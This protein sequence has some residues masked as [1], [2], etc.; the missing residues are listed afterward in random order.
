MADELIGKVLSVKKFVDGS[1]TVVF[2]HGTRHTKFQYVEGSKEKIDFP[3]ELFRT[4]A[5]SRDDNMITSFNDDHFPTGV[6]VKFREH[7]S[8]QKHDD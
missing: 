7:P 2:L 1:I 8:L 3:K 6:E 4:L 5:V